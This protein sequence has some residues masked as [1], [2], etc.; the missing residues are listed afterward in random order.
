M[1]CF[2]CTCSHP[3]GPEN[4]PNSD[5]YSDSLKQLAVERE[6]EYIRT[7]TQAEVDEYY[8]NYDEA[9]DNLAV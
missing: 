8:G 7:R 4:C 2:L 9:Y 1:P 6:S 3:G 5:D